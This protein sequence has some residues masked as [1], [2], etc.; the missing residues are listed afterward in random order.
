MNTEFWEQFLP[1]KSQNLP[2]DNNEKN[3]RHLAMPNSWVKVLEVTRN[4][5]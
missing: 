1:D 2:T 5:I 4:S 3:V